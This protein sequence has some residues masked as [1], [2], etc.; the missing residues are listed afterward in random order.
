MI[1]NGKMLSFLLVIF[2]VSSPVGL[3]YVWISMGGV[4]LPRIVM[5]VVMRMNVL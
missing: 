1:E 4:T 3:A 2:L 5:M